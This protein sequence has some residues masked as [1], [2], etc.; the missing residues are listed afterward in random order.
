M[1][2][3]R[4]WL[5]ANKLSLNVAKTEFLLIGSKSMIKKIFDF[6]PINVFI[7]CKAFGVQLTSIYRGK[8]ILKIFVEKY[9]QEF[10]RFVESNLMLT[11]KH[12]F[13]FLTPLS[14]FISTI[15]VKYEMCSV[16]LYQNNF[17]NYKI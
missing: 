17:K 9:A 5:N 16:K 14:V 15:A 8:V 13:L 11:N 10:W 4:K 7:E 12:L 1:E 2:N 6:Q 3:L